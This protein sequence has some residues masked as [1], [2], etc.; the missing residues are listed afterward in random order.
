M[1]YYIL[2]RCHFLPVVCADS[3]S[4][5]YDDD[6]S[7]S[8]TSFPSAHIQTSTPNSFSTSKL[9]HSLIYLYE[10][11][12]D[13]GTTVSKLS[14]G[15]LFY[16]LYEIFQNTMSAEIL[17][18]THRP[19]HILYALSK[20][21]DTPSEDISSNFV[22]LKQS[23]QTFR[24]TPASSCQK[25]VLNLSTLFQFLPDKQL[26]Y[27]HITKA[28]SG[29]QML[30]LIALALKCQSVGGCMVLKVDEMEGEAFSDFMYILSSYYSKTFLVKPSTSDAVS[31]DKY[32]VCVHFQA[33]KYVYY[34]PYRGQTLSHIGKVLCEQDNAPIKNIK[35]L[36]KKG[37]GPSC[38]LKNK[39]VEIKSVLW[40]HKLEATHKM[41]ALIKTNSTCLYDKVRCF[42]CVFA[43]KSAQWCLKYG[44]PYYNPF[45][46][47]DK[48]NLFLGANVQKPSGIIPSHG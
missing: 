21:D 18:H 28:N 32:V 43:D 26:V 39:L 34:E 10:P 38:H 20:Y 41:K 7:S 1:S 35:R 48:T 46:E 47:A 37:C 5:I 4:P 44:I 16:D 8:P 2:P 22:C 11:I 29:T 30:W 45:S 25:T 27:S 33:P 3:Y 40:Q 15:S 31:V 17:G 13:Y 42:Q 24:L 12:D 23:V 36:L 9:T 19:F 14:Y 6:A